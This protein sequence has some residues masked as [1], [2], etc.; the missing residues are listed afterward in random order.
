[1]GIREVIIKHFGEDDW[2]VQQMNEHGLEHGIMLA[3][4][5]IDYSNRYPTAKAIR[6]WQPPMTLDNWKVQPR[7]QAV[8]DVYKPWRSGQ[9]PL[10]RLRLR[11]R[12]IPSYTAEEYRRLKVDRRPASFGYVPHF[13]WWRRVSAALANIL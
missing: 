11:G 6:E 1:M 13:P 10:T 9:P 7:D 5:S 4:H 2:V 3:K 8:A 12:S